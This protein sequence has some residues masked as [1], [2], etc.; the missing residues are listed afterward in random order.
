MTDL[1]T[2]KEMY[3]TKD[4]YW[5]Y[6]RGDT[7]LRAE[8]IKWIKSIRLTHWKNMHGLT[9]KGLGKIEFIKEF[10]NISEEELK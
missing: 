6:I 9:Q 7:E 5:H 8:A 10:F 2:L 3:F 1:K 4:Y